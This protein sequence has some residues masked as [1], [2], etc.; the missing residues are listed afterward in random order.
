MTQVDMPFLLPHEL[1]ASVVKQGGFP[2]LDQM[3]PA[4]ADLHSQFCR[5]M[6]IDPGRCIPLGMHGDGVP[7]QAR[8]SVEVLSW[9][10]LGVGAS[11]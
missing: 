7:H 2:E 4:L 9:N 6:D 3:D 11:Q 8:K 5:S 1:L 10:M